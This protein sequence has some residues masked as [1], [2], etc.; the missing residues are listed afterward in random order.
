MTDSTPDYNTAE[1]LRK[2]KQYAE[3]AQHFA[4]LWEQNHSIYI[5]WRY[6]HCL[7]KIERVEE[8]EQIV[9]AALEK[10]PHDKYTKSELG[11]VLY[12]KELKPAK[13]E[14]DLGRAIHFANEIMVLNP[15]AFAVRL[16]ALAV[17]KIAKGR[18]KWEAVLEWASKVE[19]KDLSNEPRMFEGRRGMSD[20]ETWYVG[21][22]RALLEVERYDEAR[23]FAQQGLVEFPE[24]LFLARTAALA[25]ARSGNVQGGADELHKLLTHKRADWYMKA[26]LAELEYRLGNHAEAYRLM[27]EAVSNPQEDKYKLSCFVTLGEIAMALGKLNIAAEHV[28]LAKAVRAAN[29]WSIPADL[30]QL[31][32]AVQGGLNAIGQTWPELPQSVEQLS[33]VCQQRWLEGVTA[34]LEFIRGTLGAINP[35][36]P[37][38]FIKRVD[39]DE[40]VFVILKDIPRK[41]AYEG[42]WLEFTLKKSFDKKKNR[43]S[44][45]AANIRCAKN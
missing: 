38:A 13:E 15:E 19:G 12:D 34:G 17:M 28:A 9:R 26:D 21:R 1:T 39:G 23:S 24:E 2:N 20:R 36:K 5:G 35:D 14:S 3:A 27:C 4:A 7:R 40:N 8:A 10:Y 25:L 37:F 33:R 43:E 29:N 22:A 32:K 11:W 44:V 42:A 6:A 41:C 30:V 45:Q 16:V 31:E 18:G